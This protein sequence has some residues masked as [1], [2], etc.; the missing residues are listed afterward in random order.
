MTLL[1]DTSVVLQWFHGEGESEVQQA[2]ELLAR[3]MAAGL[4]LRKTRRGA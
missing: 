4:R 2:R 3:L 1:V